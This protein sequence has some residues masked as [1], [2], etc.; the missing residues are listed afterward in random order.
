MELAPPRRYREKA[1]SLTQL[2][3]DTKAVLSSRRLRQPISTTS[4]TAPSAQ[5]CGQRIAIAICGLHQISG[6]RSL[7]ASL[8]PIRH[9]S[10]SGLGGQTTSRMPR[11]LKPV[12]APMA[13][14]YALT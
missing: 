6:R 7:H 10:R 1:M 11:E 5:P 3:R 13:A 12:A 2:V 14:T 9:F 8:M 4:R